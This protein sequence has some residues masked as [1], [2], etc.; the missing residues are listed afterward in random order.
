MRNKGMQPGL[1]RNYQQQK[2]GA[3]VGVGKHDKMPPGNNFIVIFPPSVCSFVGSSYIH[4]NFSSTS[5]YN[6]RDIRR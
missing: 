3:L 1:R 4:M 5:R 2:E 6:S